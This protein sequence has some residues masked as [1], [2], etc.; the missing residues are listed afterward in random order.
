MNS[1]R[2]KILLHG[3]FR[4]NLGDD[5]FFRVIISRYSDVQFYIPL[6]NCDYKDKFSDLPNAKIIDFWGIDKWVHHKTYILPKLY[7]CLM[8]LHFDAVVCI[9]GSLFI[10]RQNPTAKDRLETEKYSF[11]SDWECAYK[12]HIPYLLFVQYLNSICLDILNL[13]NC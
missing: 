4:S 11:I 9:G 8:M 1:K 7:S 5:L 6:L 12:K 10:D 3:Y 13:N 2:K